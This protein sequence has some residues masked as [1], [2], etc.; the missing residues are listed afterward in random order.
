MFMLLVFVRHGLTWKKVCPPN[1]SRRQDLLFIIALEKI[2]E[3]EGQP[4]FS[5]TI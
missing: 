2:K 1:P 3:E 5:V 4:L